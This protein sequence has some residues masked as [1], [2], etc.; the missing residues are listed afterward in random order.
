MRACQV[1][2][3]CFANITICLEGT[4]LFVRPVDLVNFMI[5]LDLLG[6]TTQSK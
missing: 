1:F 2:E 5:V 6:R 3:R 4:A